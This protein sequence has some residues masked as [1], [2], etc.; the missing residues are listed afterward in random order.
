MLLSLCRDAG[1]ANRCKGK[2]GKGRKK[3][4]ERKGKGDK[5]GNIKGKERQVRRAG[6][7]GEG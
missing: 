1:Q 4:E 3:K 7:Q 5:A 2:L 6:G